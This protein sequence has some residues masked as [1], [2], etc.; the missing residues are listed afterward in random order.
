M[1][2][3]DFFLHR[4]ED[5]EK[6]ADYANAWKKDDE[7]GVVSDQP[8]RITVGD[9][10]TGPSGGYITRYTYWLVLIDSSEKFLDDGWSL[11]YLFILQNHERRSGRWNGRK[12]HASF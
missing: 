7:G 8:M 1:E 9:T 6:N 3:L 4:T 2:N 11:N 10:G 5:F 12:Y